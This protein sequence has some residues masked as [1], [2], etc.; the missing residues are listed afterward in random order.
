MFS[1][2]L[3]VDGKADKKCPDCTHTLHGIWLKSGKRQFVQQ[4]F[5]PPSLGYEGA[6]AWGRSWGGQL[7]GVWIREGAG[8]QR[9][10]ANL[11]MC[12]VQQSTIVILHYSPLDCIAHFVLCIALHALHSWVGTNQ[13]IQT[14]RPG[15]LFTKCHWMIFTVSHPLTCFSNSLMNIYNGLNG[16]HGNA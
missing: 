13:G 4:D 7:S 2:V 15:T 8:T 9:G 16:L 11:D 3:A 1:L 14:A 10:H 12:I 5:F 6:G